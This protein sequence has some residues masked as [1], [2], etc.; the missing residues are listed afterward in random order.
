MPYS[1]RFYLLTFS[2]C[3]AL[4]VTSGC[5]TLMHPKAGDFL[6]Q[7]KGENGIVTQINLTDMIQKTIDA[8]RSQG[9]YE[10]SLSDLHD[11]LYA[12]HKAG[13][14]VSGDLAP[15]VAYHRAVTIRSELRTIFHRLWKFRDDPALR[16][17][18]LDLLAT[19]VRELREAL[20]AVKT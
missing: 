3:L 6:N 13:C 11:Q 10:P 15:N 8:A 1:S 4:S 20:Q 2:F 14:Q 16:D 17:N 19:R 9:D 7:A 18:H 12:L 5:G